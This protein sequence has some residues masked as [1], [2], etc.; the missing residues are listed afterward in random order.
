MGSARAVAAIE[1]FTLNTFKWFLGTDGADVQRVLAQFQ[2]ALSQADARVVEE[3]DDVPEL[4]G[5]GTT[6]TMAFH[7]GTQLW[8]AHVGDSRAYL[9]RDGALEQITEDHTVTAEMVRRGDLRADEVPG[10]RLRHVITNVVGGGGNWACAWKPTRSTFRG[11][12]GCCSARTA[13]RRW[14]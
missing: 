13:S 12:I 8:I 3:A 10:H 6:V 9:Y 14:C 1:Q 5:M 7:L 2:A 11:G 4:S